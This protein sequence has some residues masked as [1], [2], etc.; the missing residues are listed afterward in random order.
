VLTASTAKLLLWVNPSQ[1]P[2]T[3]CQWA[4]A[5]LGEVKKLVYDSTFR[6]RAEGMSFVN[7]PPGAFPGLGKQDFRGSGEGQLLPLQL[8]F[9]PSHNRSYNPQLGKVTVL[10]CLAAAPGMV[11]YRR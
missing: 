3:R 5:G 2:S 1:L 10:A 6:K 9:V 7:S 4:P 8:L 11:L